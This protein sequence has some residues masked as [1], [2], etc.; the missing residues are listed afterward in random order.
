[1]NIASHTPSAALSATFLLV[2][3]DPLVLASVSR[4]LRS[5]T[6]G[7]TLHTAQN[8][9]DALH[10]LRTHPKI[11]VIIT[12]VFMPGRT[13]FD[14]LES[15]HANPAWADTPV[16]VLTGSA[17]SQL[18]RRALQAGAIDLLSKPVYI[19]DLL[20]RLT[21]VLRIRQTQHELRSMNETLER[22]VK[23][24]TDELERAQNE[25]LLCLA[26]ASECRDELTGM[27]LVRVANYARLLAAEVIQ[28]EAAVELLS[29]ASLLHDIGKLGVADEILNK[30]GTLDSRERAVVRGH[31]QIGHRILLAPSTEMDLTAIG[32]RFGP[33]PL[34]Q[35]A[36]QIALCH[37]ECWD[38]NGYPNGL[39][40]TDIPLEARIVSLADVYD[41]LTTRRPYHDALTHDEA[42]EI[43]RDRAGTQFDPSLVQTF[44]GLGDRIQEMS[45]QLSQR[46]AGRQETPQQT[47]RCRNAA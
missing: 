13:G 2:D 24:R 44:V 21:S 41:A 33:T 6:R 10:Q 39:S 34:I 7:W 37:H 19:E 12:D 8:V 5:I 31:C 43:I 16:I 22:R 36:A 47:D 17:E 46:V 15:V 40:G 26:M 23:E 30:P 4:G 29:R 32:P 25:S 9:N 42:M 45:V 14:L 38:G 3:D 1:M 18:K 20:A 28:D 35:L 27:H 11:D